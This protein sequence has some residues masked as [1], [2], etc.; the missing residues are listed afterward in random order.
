M[1]RTS[2]SPKQ[3][4][5][6][7]AAVQARRLAE[8]R[9]MH[10][11]MLANAHVYSSCT[12]AVAAARFNGVPCRTDSYMWCRWAVGKSSDKASSSV[13]QRRRALHT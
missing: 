8:H 13:R 6:M 5:S 12:A 9:N 3:L 11:A 4:H 7:C 2:G 1:K 10:Q